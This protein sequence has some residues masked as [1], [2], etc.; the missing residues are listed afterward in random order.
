MDDE[1]V[2]QAFRVIHQQEQEYLRWRIHLET[3]SLNGE[4]ASLNRQIRYHREISTLRKRVGAR[5]E[6]RFVRVLEHYGYPTG[7]GPYYDPT[8]EY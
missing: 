7:N 8:H 1:R 3:M 5:I 2:R 4:K 6:A